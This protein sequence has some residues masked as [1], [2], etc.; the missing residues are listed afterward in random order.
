MAAI[1][2][3][4]GKHST[5]YL[6]LTDYERLDSYVESEGDL[7]IKNLALKQADTH[8]TL[9]KH[10]NQE[11]EFITS[12]EY[13]SITEYTKGEI[14]LPAFC[15]KAEEASSDQI[16]SNAHHEPALTIADCLSRHERELALCVKPNSTETKLL[17]FA[18]SCKANERLKP[19]SRPIDH[20]INNLPQIYDGQFS[21]L[22]ASP[23]KTSKMIQR[24]RRQLLQSLKKP[25]E[26]SE[27]P[28]KH[29]TRPKSL[30]DVQDNMSS[31]LK[32]YTCETSRL[33]D[34]CIGVLKIKKP[35]S[36]FSN[37]IDGQRFVASG[38]QILTNNYIKMN[39]DELKN[40][41]FFKNYQKGIP[42]KVSIAIVY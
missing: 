4:D 11:R 1:Q 28:I 35:S 39:E 7:L 31:G 15:L 23:I 27:K 5:K 12:H 26:I 32:T 38:T 29:F 6:N 22:N 41:P 20:P 19:D 10:L 9:E 25:I 14:T 36:Q 8:L 18:L 34:Q 24:K 13:V 30:W 33:A 3:Q 17:A 21:H 37:Y 16:S 42:S 40:L 2:K